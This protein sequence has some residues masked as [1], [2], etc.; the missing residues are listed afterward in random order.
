MLALLEV[1]VPKVACANTFEFP[2]P[3][4]GLPTSTWLGAL[5]ISMRNWSDALSAIPKSLIVETSKFPYLGPIRLLRAQ[6]RNSGATVLVKAAGS[7][8]P[9]AFGFG[10]TGS[11]PDTPL[12]RL[13]TE[14][15]APAHSEP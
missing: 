15:P 14:T 10:N 2:Q 3:V 13:L 6:F 8:Q 1:I 5:N 7:N 11:T 9:C 4:A 12:S